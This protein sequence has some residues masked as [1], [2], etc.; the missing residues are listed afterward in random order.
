MELNAGQSDARE[1]VGRFLEDERAWLA[2]V[3][4]YAGTGKTTL[5]RVLA[6]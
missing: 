3:T 4:G 6:D 5:I 1:M 2:R